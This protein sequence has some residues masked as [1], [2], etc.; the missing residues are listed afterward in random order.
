MA[1]MRST[2]RSR[3]MTE[4]CSRSRRRSGRFVGGRAIRLKKVGTN[5]PLTRQFVRTFLGGAL[6]CR[7]QALDRLP[8]VVNG[9]VGGGGLGR[10]G[11]DARAGDSQG[12]LRVSQRAAG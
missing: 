4:R 8:E 5:P 1:P 11:Q 2:C 9:E 7:W 10:G 3:F 12:G 6:E